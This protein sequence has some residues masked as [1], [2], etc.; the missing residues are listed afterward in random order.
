[1]KKFYP[2]GY[3]AAA[4]SMMKSRNAQANAG[5]FLDKL[6]AG[7]SLLDVGCGPG[8]ITVGIAKALSPG[9]VVGIDI[10]ASQVELGR[11]HAREEGVE[12]CSFQAASVLDLPMDDASFD[13]VYGH[14]I[15]MQFK[16]P[17]PVLDE[18]IRVLKPGGLVGFRE[19]D[20]GASLFHDEDSSM[21]AVL[22]NLRRSVFQNDGNP[23]IGRQLPSIL[24]SAGLELV[25]VSAQYNYA[26]SPTAKQRMYGAMAELWDQADFPAQAEELGWISAAERKAMA[27]RLEKEGADPA[28]FSGTTYVEVVARKL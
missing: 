16:D 8:S 15:L 6:T 27:D 1:M 4:V 26:S 7:S 28:S 25:D 23:D 18:V 5:F 22:F 19:I 2:F 24:S 11:Q 10:E 20:L 3:G 21:K 14:T 13:A 9:N 17:A 12:N